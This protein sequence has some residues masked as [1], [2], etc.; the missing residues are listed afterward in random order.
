MAQLVRAALATRS[1]ALSG[2][3]IKAPGFAG[4]YLPEV[5]GETAHGGAGCRRRARAWSPPGV[6]V[7]RKAIDFPASAVSPSAHLPLKVPPARKRR[8][9]VRRV[10]IWASIL[11]VRACARIRAS[12]DIRLRSVLNFL[13]TGQPVSLQAASLSG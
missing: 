13:A 7:G 12:G 3:H 9:R 6:A 5:P 2:S 11:A 4:G 10:P 1:A 8:P